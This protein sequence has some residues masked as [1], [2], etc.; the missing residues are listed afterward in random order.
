MPGALYTDFFNRESD[1]QHLNWEAIQAR[2]FREPE[3]KEGKQAEFLLR[4][5]FPWHLVE[6]I[7]VHNSEVL[8]NVR[9]FEG[10]KQAIV[11]IEPAWYY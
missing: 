7:G 10:V 3:T 6:K 5:A 1:L 4:E 9:S 2:D 8:V 11:H